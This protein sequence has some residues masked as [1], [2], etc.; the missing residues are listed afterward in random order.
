MAEHQKAFDAMKKIVAREALLAYP[1][2][3]KPFEIHTDACQVQL[4]SVISQKG[5]PI[6]FYSRKLNSAQ[7]NYTTHEK[8]LLSIVETLKEFKTILFGHELVIWTDHKNLTYETVSANTDRVLRWR[9]LLE[10]Y[11]IT[12]KYIKGED[13]VYADAISRLPPVHDCPT[14]IEENNHEEVIM[15]LS[16]E[17]QEIP[18]PMETGRVY[19]EQQNELAKNRKFRLDTRLKKNSSI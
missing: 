16:P 1:D 4:G 7:K 5:R 6:A 11:K 3:S 2:F 8:E 17:E 12:L 14:E 9:L 13:N 18:F 15:A 10:E 19:T